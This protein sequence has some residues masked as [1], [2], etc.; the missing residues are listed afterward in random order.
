MVEDVFA[1]R[2]L[3][4]RARRVGVPA[5]AVLVYRRPRNVLRGREPF[6]EADTGRGGRELHW[7][8]WPRV[9]GS[10]C[11]HMLRRFLQQ[12]HGCRGLLWQWCRWFGPRILRCCCKL[13][14]LRLRPRGG[15][16]HMLR[17]NDHHQDKDIDHDHHSHDHN[18]KHIFNKHNRKFNHF[19][20]FH[21][22]NINTHNDHAQLDDHK[23]NN[24]YSQHN[25]H[26]HIH[27]HIHVVYYT[28]SYHYSDE[29]LHNH[30]H[31]ARNKV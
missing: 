11:G 4:P 2:A 21:Y 19:H 13:R 24:T 26:I 20:D 7:C 6:I 15:C 29:Y 23:P 3:Q 17:H 10:G 8:A 28:H 27:I 25:F 5:C 14:R 12:H 18:Y 16:I 30:V 1:V 31:D 22:F 9:R